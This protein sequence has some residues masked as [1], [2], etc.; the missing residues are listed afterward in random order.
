MFRQSVVLSEKGRRHPRFA[1][2]LGVVLS[3]GEAYYF[4]ETENVSEKGLRLRPKKAFPVGTQHRLV[5]GRPPRLR[6]ID[7]IGVVRW[8]ETG[9]GVGVEF[10][11]ISANDQQALREFL[12]S[13]P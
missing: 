6:R 1:L 7:A 10:T 4:A 9:K 11:S 5:F 13:Q 3:T 8:C 2:S 12:N